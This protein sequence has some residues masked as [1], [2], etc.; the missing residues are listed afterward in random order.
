M[1]AADASEAAGAVC[2]SSELTERAHS[3]LRAPQREGHSSIEEEVAIFSAFDGIGG[4]RRAFE[5][6]GAT[7]ALFMS[8]EIDAEALRVVRRV[9][10]DVV[11]LGD[12]C[13]LEAATVAQVIRSRGRITTVLASAGFPCQG[14]SGLNAQRKGLRD[15]R[16]SLVYA[17]TDLLNELDRLMPEITFDLL[18]ENV[19]SGPAPDVAKVPELLGR[20]PTQIDASDFAHAHRPRLYRHTWDLVPT[21]YF[22]AEKVL[23]NGV[24]G[25]FAEKTKV[26][27]QASSPSVSEWLDQGSTFEGTENGRRLPTLVRWIPRGKPPF[28]PA[29]IDGCPADALARWEAAEFAVAPYQFKAANCV[30]RASGAL[31]PPTAREREVLIGFARDH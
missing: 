6:T 20:V 28:M 23:L 14:M 4:I 2:S 15:P 18:V 13:K 8:C 16:S 9:W 17:F 21:P 27:V 31:E 19:A 22:V 25:K 5:L 1:A 29:G 26:K 30:T 10:P 7:P 12:I 3:L 24:E 11:E